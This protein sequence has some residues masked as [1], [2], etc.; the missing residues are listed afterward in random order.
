MALRPLWR[1]RFDIF[2]LER[3]YNQIRYAL[4]IQ[5]EFLGYIWV[6]TLPEKI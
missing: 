4:V 1:I 6:Y 2:K 5:D 3:A